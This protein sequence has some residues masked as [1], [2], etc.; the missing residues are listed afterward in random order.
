L[1]N[2]S[3]N[4]F[5]FLEPIPKK[6]IYDKRRRGYMEEKQRKIKKLIK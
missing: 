5:T 3:Y 4:R 2:A 6:V 1:W